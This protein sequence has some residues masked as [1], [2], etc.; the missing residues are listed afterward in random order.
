MDSNA[1]WMSLSLI[2][3]QQQCPPTLT[4]GMKLCGKKNVCGRFAKQFG[5]VVAIMIV[6][7]LVFMWL[8]LPNVNPSGSCTALCSVSYVGGG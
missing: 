6:S 2:R 7:G 1:Y 4:L 5:F 8:E 3:F